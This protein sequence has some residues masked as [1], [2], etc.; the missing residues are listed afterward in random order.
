MYHTGCVILK[1]RIVVT[2][3]NPDLD[4]IFSVWLIKRFLP[5]WEKA[6]VKFVPAGQTYEGKPPDSDSNILHCD[7]GGGKF[8]HHQT[9]DF[10]CAASLVWQEILSQNPKI[11]NGQKEAIKRMVKIVNEVDHARFLAWPEPT[12]DCWDFCFHQALGGM[13]G[14]FNDEPEKI[15]E[16]SLPVIDGIFRIF[17]EKVEAE[18]ILKNGLEFKTKWG[19]GI[20]METD[21]AEATYLALKLG[22]ALVVRKKPKTGHLGLY[23]NW[24]N[25]V[26][27]YRVYQILKRKDPKADWFYHK[28]GCM[29]LNGSTSNPKMKAT[30]LSLE[31]VI[32][33][34]K[35]R[36]T[37]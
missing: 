23:G 16:H 8:D 33:I 22:C 11:K 2:H 30:K 32:E 18:E 5:G 27:L 26:N 29:V 3:I 37:K 7:T 17:S 4:A 28:S 13:V 24:Q 9:K 6:E 12:S 35:I 21:N 31:E 25:G 34:L 19:K 15:I 10:V 14:S 36:K 1:M 20:A